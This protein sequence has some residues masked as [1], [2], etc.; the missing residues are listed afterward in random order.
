MK[1]LSFD[2]MQKIEGGACDVTYMFNGS[3]ADFTA[4]LQ[5]LENGP[6]NW[7]AQGQLL[8]NLYNNGC[9]ILQE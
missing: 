6:S 5:A 3:A 7:Q 4:V 2:K 1:T 8:T 9:I